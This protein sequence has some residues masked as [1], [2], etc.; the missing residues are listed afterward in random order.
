[1]RGSGRRRC[2]GRSWKTTT[3]SRFRFR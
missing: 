2:S 1:M 3:R